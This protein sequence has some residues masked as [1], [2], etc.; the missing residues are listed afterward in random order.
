M[1]VNV[2]IV[3]KLPGAKRMDGFLHAKLDKDKWVIC[4]D[5]DI[6][7]T[8]FCR[9]SFYLMYVKPYLKEIPDHKY[10]I[11]E[12]MLKIVP[13]NES[14]WTFIFVHTDASSDSD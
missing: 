5:A 7:P 9:D 8:Q 12:W 11:Y 6:D 1:L 14:L 13:I 2:F 4:L 10:D 3:E